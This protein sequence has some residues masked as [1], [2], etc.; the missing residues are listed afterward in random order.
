[1]TKISSIIG[2]PILPEHFPSFTP[3]LLRVRENSNILEPMMLF[4]YSSLPDS[5]TFKSLIL[6]DPSYYLYR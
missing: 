4:Q 6:G 5:H 3:K 1:M 2:T